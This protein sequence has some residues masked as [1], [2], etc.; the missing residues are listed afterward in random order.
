[1]FEIG[2]PVSFSVVEDRK[3]GRPRAED[4]QLH[5]FGAGGSRLGA[6]HDHAHID[7]CSLLQVAACRVLC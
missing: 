7:A 5:F 3:T 6:S 4:L 1:M 2:T